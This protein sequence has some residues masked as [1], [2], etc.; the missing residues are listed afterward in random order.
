M[1]VAAVVMMETGDDMTQVWL[2]VDGGDDTD[3]RELAD[4]TAQLRRRLL[5]L[6]VE[7]V[8][9]VHSEDIPPGAKPAEAIAIGALVVTTAPAALKAVVG[10]VDSWL[11]NRP[12]RSA[13]VTIDGD[14]MELA[15]ISRTEQ[16]QLLQAFLDKHTKQ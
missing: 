2:A 10:L 12:V 9:L 8:E 16:Q 7:R 5:E 6:D 11:R 1:L 13:T 14:S 3:A 4:L 15:K